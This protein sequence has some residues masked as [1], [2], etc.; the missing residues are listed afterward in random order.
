MRRAAIA[1]IACLALLGVALG[2]FVGARALVSSEEDQVGH[3]KE[4]PGADVDKILEQGRQVTW[5]AAEKALEKAKEAT[6]LDNAKPRFKG[7]L[8]DFTVGQTSEWPQC[9]LATQRV[10]DLDAIKASELYSSALGENVEAGACADGTIIS[11]FVEH[12]VGRFYFVGP[13]GVPY[14]APADRLRLLTVGGK[15][16]IAEIP[17]PDNFVSDA[18]L[19]VIQRFPTGQEP[20]IAIGVDIMNDLDGAIKLAERI[21]GVTP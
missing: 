16:A 10:D 20:G 9:P 21:M 6:A 4:A 3:V 15:P 19:M 17:I 2:A 12:H 13:P 11:V 7:Q 1:A 14:E 18:R 5:L 8:G